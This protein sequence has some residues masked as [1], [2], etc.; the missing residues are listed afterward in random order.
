MTTES[1][2]ACDSVPTDETLLSEHESSTQKPRGP[3]RLPAAL[4]AEAFD[5]LAEEI[6]RR[7]TARIP[8]QLEEQLAELRQFSRNIAKRVQALTDML[9]PLADRLAEW[10]PAAAAPPAAE[11]TPPSS[12]GWEAIL[13]GEELC[14]HESLTEDRRQLL[15]DVAASAPSAVALA[16]RL[17]QV[18]T[19]SADELPLL[20]KDVGEAFYRWRRAPSDAEDPFEQALVAFLQRRLEAAGLRNRIERVRVGDRFDSTRHN[21]AQRGMEVAEVQGWI[22]LRDNGKPLSRANVALR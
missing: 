4:F 9:K 21:S 2:P 13:L 12:D 3:D 20:A 15:G 22:V 16:S 17:M 11:R 1:T 8:S 18:P 14:R 6:E 19:A 7:L 5:A 10:P